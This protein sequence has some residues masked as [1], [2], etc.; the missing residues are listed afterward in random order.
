[1]GAVRVLALVFGAG[2]LLQAQH[3][4]TRG[5]AE[6]GEQLFIEN[7]AICHGPEGDAVPGVALAKG[8]F[9]H[10]SSD[11]ELGRVI[12]NGIPGTAMPPANFHEHQ[13][14]ALISYL[15]SMTA[16]IASS[17]TKLGDATRGRTL[18]EGKG[19]C[20][21][22]HRVSGKGSYLGPELTDVGLTRRSAQLERSVLEP[23]AEILP[24]NR[25]VRVV[26]KDGNGVTGRLLNLDTF[27]IQLMDSNERLRSFLKE[28]L[29]EFDFVD[30][31]SMPSYKGKLSKEEV[32]DVVAYLAALKGVSRQ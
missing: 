25:F 28:N 32:A 18:F 16:S 10:A 31:S 24:Q 21:K 4:Y 11:E 15:R 20:L 14:T 26:T 12:T 23:D 22:C 19:E 29:T 13:V 27:T 30:K 5:D 6:A 9:R 8:Q 3:A 1:M 7:C 2:I 17:T